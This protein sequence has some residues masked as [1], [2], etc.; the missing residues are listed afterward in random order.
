MRTKFSK[1]KRRSSKPFASKRPSSKQPVSQDLAVEDRAALAVLDLDHPEIGIALE[2]T[3]DIGVGGLLID[4]SLAGC[5]DPGAFSV[6]AAGL[7][8]Y[9]ET[10]IAAIELEQYGAGVLV[11]PSRHRDRH[12]AKRA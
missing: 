2:L 3:G 4:E 9:G 12:G 11:A 7:S 10:E 1:L 5:P 6:F 8:Q